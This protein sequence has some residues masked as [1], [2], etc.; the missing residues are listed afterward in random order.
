[1]DYVI[2]FFDGMRA[3]EFVPG[4]DNCTYFTRNTQYDFIWMSN[5]LRDT[6]DDEQ[7]LVESQFFNVTGTLADD[8]PDAIYYCYLLP[9]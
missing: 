5:Y 4:S 1:M 2:S 9:V 3:E 6:A 8:L 7:V